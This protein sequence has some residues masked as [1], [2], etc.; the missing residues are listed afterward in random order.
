[1]RS[2][3]VLSVTELPKAASAQTWSR[4]IRRLL[5]VHPCCPLVA[6]RRRS[7]HNRAVGSNRGLSLIG[8]RMPGGSGSAVLQFTP[9]SVRDMLFYED[10]DSL[11]IFA[12]IPANWIRPS[13]HIGI[14]SALPPW[15]ERSSC[16]LTI[17]KTAKCSCTPG[18]RSPYRK[19]LCASLSPPAPNSP[20]SMSIAVQ[21]PASA[22][23]P[24]C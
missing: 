4:C 10:G 19:L 21:S 15:V 1:M 6:F 5:S 16:A 3:N 13:E 17:H 22:Q 12:G 7:T 11:H 18:L 24:L 23:I 8:P 9:S 2:L 14:S 20:P